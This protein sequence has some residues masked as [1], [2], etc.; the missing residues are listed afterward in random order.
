MA[1]KS[2]PRT[3]EGKDRPEFNKSIDLHAL[4]EVG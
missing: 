3:T 4:S 2:A 1:N